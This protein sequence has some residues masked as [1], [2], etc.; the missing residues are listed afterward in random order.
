MKTIRFLLCFLFLAS[1]CFSCAY[2]VPR[3]PGWLVVVMPA[4]PSSLNILTSNDASTGAVLGYLMESLADRN[5]ATLE[6]RPKLAERWDISPDHL[7]FTYYLRRDVQWHDGHPF[8][9]DDVIYSYA[10]I[11]D[12]KVDAAVLRDYYKDV[13]RVEKLDDYTVRFVYRYPYFMAF[14]FTAGIP[15]VPKH[16]FDD[17]TDFNIHPVGRQPIGTGPYRFVEWVTSRR[18]VLERN[19]HYWATP[20]AVDGV[21]FR[22]IPE[23]SVAFQA[24]KKGEVDFIDLYPVQWARQTASP[25]FLARF[26]KYRYFPPILSYIG[27]NMRRPFFSDR[28]VRRA[29]TLLIDR[30]RILARILYGQGQI[31]SGFAYPFHSSYDQSIAPW[32]YDP[33]EAGRLLEQAG[34]IDHDGDGIRDK[35]GIPFRFRFL[36]QPASR[37]GEPL[38]GILREDFRKA[39]II[40]DAQRLEWTTYVKNINGR[41][42]DAML[43]GWGGPVESDPYQIWHSSQAAKGSNHVGFVNAD[44]DRLIETARREFN[45]AVRAQWYRQLHRILH[46][47]QPYTFLYNFAELEALDRRFTNVHAYTLGF[48]SMEW[49]VNRDVQLWQ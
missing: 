27:W 24:L 47:E 43:G 41:A 46:E 17:G 26:A 32:P 2:R 9:A 48:E 28:L 8:T 7:Q 49:G 37:L 16:A 42:Y 22:L 14:E 39:G 3:D 23:R 13:S 10:R 19:P 33:A 40:V 36:Y 30:E 31:V 12:P 29:M 5:P 44:A 20:P 21:I 1:C 35:D 18:I 38:A 15:I 34:W 6:W 11:K 25:K 4:D 45:P